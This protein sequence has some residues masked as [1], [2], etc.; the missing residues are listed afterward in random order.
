MD[1]LS[2]SGAVGIE[3]ASFQSGEPGTIPDTLQQ[4]PDTQTQPAAEIQADV[5]SVPDGQV[6]P[7]E[8]APAALSYDLKIDSLL[9]PLTDEQRAEISSS[10]MDK[11]VFTR[12][13]DQFFTVGA[14]ATTAFSALLAAG[15]IR[16][17]GDP[18]TVIKEVGV[19]AGVTLLALTGRYIINAHLQ[20]QIKSE[21]MQVAQEYSDKIHDA[22]T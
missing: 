7:I 17:G 22:T 8:A 13:W 21:V 11:T 18:Q 5:A 20:K 1:S 2:E 12:M 6:P 15:A 14:A 10:A 9:R 19:Y 3:E 16:E 4:D